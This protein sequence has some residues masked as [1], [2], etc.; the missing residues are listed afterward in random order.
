VT[1]KTDA[2]N[3]YSENPLDTR[4]QFLKG[5]GPRLAAIFGARGIISLK[6]LI[7]FF[8]RKY[9]DRSKIIKINELKE[10]ESA[11]L[12]LTVHNCQLRPLRG[13]FQKLFEVRAKD[14]NGEWISLKWF[15]VFKGFELKFEP[16]TKIMATGMVKTFGALREMVHPEIQFDLGDDLH[17]GRI[18]PI[19]TEIEGVPTKS[20]RKIIDLALT[21]A[22][23]AIKDELPIDLLKRHNFPPLA[24][25]IRE[26]H[27]PSENQDPENASQKFTDFKSPAH[28]RLIYEEFFKFEYHVLSR[29]L[30]HEKELGI[31][32]NLKQLNESLTE[33]KKKLGFT[34]THDQV[35]SIN[36]IFS[37]LAKPHPMNRLLQGDVGAGKT[38]VALLSALS[39][40]DQGYQVA[41]MAPTEILAEQHFQNTLRIFGAHL[42]VKMLVGK[43][44]AVER[45]SVQALLDS[46][47]PALLIGTHALI[48]DPVVFK[49][50]G[51]VVIDEQHRFGVDQR[52]KLREKSKIQPHMLV[53]TATPIPR[54]LALTAYGDL[55]VSIIRER[56][57]GRTPIKTYLVRQAEHARMI[58][59]IKTEIRDGRQAYFIFPLVNDSEEEGFTHLKSAV[60]AAETLANETFPEFRVGLLHG[61]LS[62][63]EKAQ[64]M[65]RFRKN[66]VQILVATTVV[67]VGV[68]VPNATIMVIEHPERFGLSQ[69]HQLRG[70]IGR[71][72]HA[73]TCFLR[74]DR[75]ASVPT[76]ERLEVM[77]ETEDGF[78]IAEADLELRG[79]GEFLGTRQSGAL[80]FK[81]ASLIRDQDWL[82]KAR[83]DAIEILEKDPDL[84]DSD[85]QPFKKY[86][87]NAGKVEGSQLKTS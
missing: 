48:E 85:H 63:N 81:I 26:V 45:R 72:L 61:Q 8:P 87:Q 51:L 37:D 25:A 74:I 31:G 21:L 59:K 62:S 38:A 39:V 67:E 2:K 65:E 12:E 29:K 19:Y 56:P 57:P 17:V 13:R 49:K 69:L 11:T 46:E 68:D 41:I 4:V 58:E 42:P 78:K 34:L 23:P 84:K 64:I 22:A 60:S 44:G 50:L 40:M 6:D 70:R 79:P 14:A 71:G 16:G 5:V 75:P 1:K 83:N 9:E 47:S 53:M 82:V 55:S 66:E 3:T 15:R 76:P 10:G 7:Y 36:E 30:H 18:I 32:F 54:T 80:P 43:T 77:C 27:F 52:R 86:L 33:W 73:S 20:L 28:E 35:K 24:R